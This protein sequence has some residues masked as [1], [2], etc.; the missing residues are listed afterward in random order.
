MNY[1]EEIEQEF[2]KI[3]GRWTPLAPLDWALAQTWETKQIPL[4]V[5]FRAMDDVHKKFIA[6]NPKRTDTINSLRYF[7]KGVDKEF[8]EWQTSQ[9]G[10]AL[11][12]PTTEENTM[13]Y[14]DDYV[15]SVETDIL[16]YFAKQF[17]RKNLPEPLN[18]AAQNALIELLALIKETAKSEMSD[19]DL[20]TRLE[21]ISAD[22]ELS[23]AVSIPADVRTR[24]IETFKRDY[25]NIT[26][27]A[28]SRQ[29]LLIKQAYAHFGLPKLTLFEL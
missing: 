26:I 20:E 24:M 13:N 12:I 17:D 25:A 19:T 4:S 27:T 10:K 5:V 21:K 7:E 8:A 28:E 15:A 16:D 18:S 22:L 9:V 6:A 11:E 1:L 14:L 29:K 2:S 23:L 3:R